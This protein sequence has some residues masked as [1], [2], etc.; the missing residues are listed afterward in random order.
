MI[1][2]KNTDDYLFIDDNLIESSLKSNKYNLTELEI[3]D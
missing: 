3:K 2:S 1:L